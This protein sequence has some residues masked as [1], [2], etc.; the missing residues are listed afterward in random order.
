MFLRLIIFTWLS[1]SWIIRKTSRHKE[2]IWA[3]DLAA[4]IQVS[5]IGYMS[6]GAFLGLQYFDLFYHLIAVIVVT[7]LVVKERLAQMPAT[8]SVRKGLL[9]KTI[10]PRPT[11]QPVLE[12]R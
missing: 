2:L 5:L 3:R 1:A 10:P 9:P 4:M 8:E 11:D 7:K 6:A 12:R